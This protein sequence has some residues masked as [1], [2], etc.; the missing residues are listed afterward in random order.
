MKTI[1]KFTFEPAFNLNTIINLEMPDNPEILCV[2]NQDEEICLW[3]IVE[4]TNEIYHFTFDIIPTGTE[5]ID[6]YN[7][8]RTYIDT[9]LLNDG[10]L[11][12]H[13]F[14]REIK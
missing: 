8:K 1:W 7:I 3:A 9:V 2:K 11:V 13:I 4:T 14:K 12:F 10:K 5:L 6:S